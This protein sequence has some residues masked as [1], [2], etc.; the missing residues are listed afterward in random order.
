MDEIVAH[1]V[2]L[3]NESGQTIGILSKIDVLDFIRQ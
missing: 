1:N 2:V 3:V